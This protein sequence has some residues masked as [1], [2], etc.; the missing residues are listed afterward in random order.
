MSICQR[1]RCKSTGRCCREPIEREPLRFISFTLPELLRL[2]P[3]DFDELDELAGD[4][5]RQRT[6][7]RVRRW[8]WAQQDR[9]AQ[10]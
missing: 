3:Q 10:K 4:P 5:E 9:E 8:G 1:T 7:W 6:W 2:T